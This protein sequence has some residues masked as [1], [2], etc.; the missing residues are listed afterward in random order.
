MIKTGEIDAAWSA[1]REIVVVQNW[2]QELK[3]LV[4][5]N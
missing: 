4:L 1:P 2:D 3:R 5:V